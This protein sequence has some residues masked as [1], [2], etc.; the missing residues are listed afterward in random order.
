MGVT[1]PDIESICNGGIVVNLKADDVVAINNLRHACQF[2]L[3]NIKHP[4]DFP[5][6]CEINMYLDSNLI[7][8]AV[9]IRNVPVTIGGT[10]WKPDLPIESNEEELVD[11]LRIVNSTEG[12]LASCFMVWEDRW[13]LMETKERVCSQE[14]M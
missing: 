2:V 6:L 8:G 3:E 12:P 5:Y 11:I 13:S 9:F 1:F 4:I 7:R 10:T 14:T